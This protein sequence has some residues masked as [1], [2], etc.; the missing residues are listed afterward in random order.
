MK[1]I[2]ALTIVAMVA[3]AA[4]S[5][6]ARVALGHDAIDAASYTLIRIV[7][8]AGFLF[9][10]SW[11]MS[12]KAAAPSRPGLKGNWVSAAALFVYAIAFS[13]AYLALGAAMG[14]LVLF[15]SVQATMIVWSLSQGARPARG[16]VVGFVAAFVGFVYL[17]L[18]GVGRPD[19]QGTV[20]MTLSGVA[21]GVYTLKGRGS[22]SPLADTAGNFVRAS[23]FCLPLGVFALADPNLTFG[24]VSLAL[25]SGVVASGLGY[26][27]WYLALPSLTTFQAALV[28]LS[29]PVI[30]AAGAIVLLDETLTLRF[31][32]VSVVVLGG[33][34]LAIVSKHRTT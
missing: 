29:V 32:L 31:A 25:A 22:S 26:A 20:L 27:I 15:S 30:T 28:Q 21:W 34:A 11:R 4:N 10:V 7:S 14:A 24:G 16:E 17:V 18:P 13:Y 2:A 1:S 3:F 6:L 23:A 5:L 8:G 12:A 9:L 19:P 33:I